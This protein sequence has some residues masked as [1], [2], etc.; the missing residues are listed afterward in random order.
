MSLQEVALG[1]GAVV[2]A[3]TAVLSVARAD[4]DGGGAAL[5][6]AAKAAFEDG[7][8]EEADARLG[9]L[10]RNYPESRAAAAYLACTAWALGQGD[11]AA[12]AMQ[13]LG[14]SRVDF[15]EGGRC[16]TSTTPLVTFDVKRLDRVWL[17]HLRAAVDDPEQVALARKAEAAPDS[18]T[19]VPAVYWACLSRRAG[20][21]LLAAFQHEIASDLVA[22]PGVTVPPLSKVCP[23]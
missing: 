2:V 23:S 15:R 3:A 10:G 16:F 8:Y 19:P 9:E 13:V 7:R 21:P 11:R 22:P 6:T 1:V 5:L 20:L 18:T 14:L 4:V 12:V 17:V